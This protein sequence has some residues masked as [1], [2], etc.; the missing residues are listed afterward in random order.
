M[1]LYQTFSFVVFW[2]CSALVY[3][4]GLLL[5]PDRWTVCHCKWGGVGRWFSSCSS[6]VSSHSL[7]IF[8][9][10]W[11]WL[12]C[13]N[14]VLF[15]IVVHGPLVPLYCLL[16]LFN[17]PSLLFLLGWLLMTCSLCLFLTLLSWKWLV[18]STRLSSKSFLVSFSYFFWWF[19]LFF[20]FSDGSEFFC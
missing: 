10:L 2:L 12:S 3:W 5:V 7:I 4:S 14:W 1:S 13:S 15:P 17:R 11:A 19:A 8:C 16:C 9:V 6:V 20:L 18:A